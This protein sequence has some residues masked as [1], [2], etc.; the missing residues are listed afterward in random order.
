MGFFRRKWRRG[1]GQKA[2]EKVFEHR[3]RL[4]AQAWRSKG[5]AGP[6]LGNGYLDHGETM[7]VYFIMT[8]IPPARSASNPFDDHEIKHRGR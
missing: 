3:N 7:V 5:T 6:R 4:T 1:G 8:Q 2:F